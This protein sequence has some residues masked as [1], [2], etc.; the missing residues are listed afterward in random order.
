MPNIHTVTL[1]PAMDQIL[2]L[3]SFQPEVTNRLTGST[4]GLGG[5]GTHVSINLKQ[6]GLANTAFG[7]VHGQTGERIIQMLEEQ[8]ITVHFLQE[9]SQNSRTNYLLIEENG[10]CTCLSSQGVSLSEQNISDFILYMKQHIQDGDYLILSGD[11]SNCPDAFVYNTI[12]KAMRSKHLKVFL[13]ASGET[14]KKCILE[15]P[16]LIKPNLD[17]LSYLC[18]RALSSEPEI[19]SALQSLDS[20]DIPVIAVSL[21]GSGS[22][23]RSK[24]G[25]FRVRTPKVHVRNTIGCGDCFLSGLI[26]GLHQGLSM[27]ETLRTATAIS[28]ATAESALSVGFDLQR[29]KQLIPEVSIEKI[30]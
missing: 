19:L 26:Y 14:L 1:N 13:D 29:A 30:D 20:F 21:G 25:T 28:A 22:L 3:P 5:K 2:Y 27:D 9:S 24:S 4:Q 6:L 11:A 10:T 7:I 17:E 23:V 16:F 15:K 8:G 12:M 18:D